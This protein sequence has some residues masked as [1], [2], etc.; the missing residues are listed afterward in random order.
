MK[1]ATIAFHGTR[2][3]ED[4]IN[5]EG[6]KAPGCVNV[7]KMIDEALENF[8]IPLSKALENENF[9]DQYDFTT[10]HWGTCMDSVWATTDKENCC[11]YAK[12]GPEKLSVPLSLLDLSRE[13]IQ[14]YTS[15]KFG[16]PKCVTFQIP[17]GEIIYEGMTNNPLPNISPSKILSIEKCSV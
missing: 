15:E 11:S 14:Q 6:L 7:K 8:N 13:E 10:K 12:S 1:L 3:S 9:K 17:E 5:R 4:L 2:I 16:E